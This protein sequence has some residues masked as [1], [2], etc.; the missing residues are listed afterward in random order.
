[1]ADGKELWGW[2][3]RKRRLRKKYANMYNDKIKA[4]VA[5]RKAERK[6]G[7][8]LEEK[9]SRRPPPEETGQS[10]QRH[11]ASCSWRGAEVNQLQD[12]GETHHPRKSLTQ[13]H[14]PWLAVI[15]GKQARH[16]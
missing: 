16:D 15:S 12:F 5:E 8:S 7:S 9:Q 11:L 4:A 13:T 10:Q 1:V 3:K 2:N 6:P 14:S